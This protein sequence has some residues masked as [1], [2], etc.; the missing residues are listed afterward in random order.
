MSVNQKASEWDYVSPKHIIVYFDNEYVISL[1]VYWMNA[2]YKLHGIKGYKT[3]HKDV[4][5]GAQ[6]CDAFHTV[7]YG[8]PLHPCAHPIQEQ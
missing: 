4:Q 3:I 5:G 8:K 7:A 6:G 2:C 1:L